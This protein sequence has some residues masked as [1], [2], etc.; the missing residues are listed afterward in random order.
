M[1]NVGYVALLLALV[2]SIYAAVAA[3][4]AGD[5]DR[6]A[7]TLPGEFGAMATAQEIGI[8]MGDIPAGIF[9]TRP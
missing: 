9:F 1:A 4:E 2:L 8:Q 6:V 5:I 3:L 7:Q